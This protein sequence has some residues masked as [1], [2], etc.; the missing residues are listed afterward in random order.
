MIKNISGFILWIC[1]WNISGNIPS[2]IK[3]SVMIIAP[4]TSLW[5]FIIGRLACWKL[6][7]NGKFLIK[8]EFFIFPMNIFLKALGAL[9]VNRSKGANIVNQSIEILKN[10]E[11]VTIILTPEGTRK[12][13]ENWKKG[14]YYIAERTSVP[15]V[16]GYLNYRDKKGGVSEIF[17]PTGNFEKDLKYIEEAYRKIAFAKHPEKF[18]LSGK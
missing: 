16:L 2:N 9:A 8:K 10:R 13:T 11:R 12:Y 1:G 4:H 6:G 5:D 15:V 7:I 17:Y 18:N 14:F 3:K